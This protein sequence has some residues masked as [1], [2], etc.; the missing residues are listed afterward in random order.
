MIAQRETERY[1]LEILKS[2]GGLY[3]RLYDKIRGGTR[4][5]SCDTAEKALQWLRWATV[6]SSRPLKEQG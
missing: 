2:P 5:L 4:Y 1:I 6:A 3:L